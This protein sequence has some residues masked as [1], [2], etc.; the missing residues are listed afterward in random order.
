MSTDSLEVLPDDP[1]KR[2]VTEER[3]E[4]LGAAFSTDVGRHALARAWMSAEMKFRRRKSRDGQ[5]TS[6]T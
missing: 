2:R 4:I 3:E 6:H 1:R 5:T